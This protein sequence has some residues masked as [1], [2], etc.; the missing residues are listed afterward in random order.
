M[1]SRGNETYKSSTHS[2]KHRAECMKRKV[3]EQQRHT[4]LSIFQYGLLGLNHLL[5][6]INEFSI[7][8]LCQLKW[9]YNIQFSMVFWLL[10]LFTIILFIIII[11]ICKLSYSLLKP[12]AMEHENGWNFC[13]TFFVQYVNVSSYH[14]P[15]SN[16][17]TSAHNH[18]FFEKRF[19]F[20]AT[21]FLLDLR[22][23]CIL[24]RDSWSMVESL[25]LPSARSSFVDCRGNIR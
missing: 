11:V 5:S 2:A 12:N 8:N 13:Y 1:Q 9:I 23:Y 3:R 21:L 4:I 18:P 10:P 6:A 22:V 15:A 20:P 24:C 25:S 19:F 16:M 7:E 17:K 14:R